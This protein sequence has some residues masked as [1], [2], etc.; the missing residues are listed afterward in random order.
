ME[1]ENNAKIGQHVLQDWTPY[2][3]YTKLQYNIMSSFIIYNV[4]EAGNN[5]KI[6]QPILQD[7]TPYNIYTKLQYNIMSSFIIAIFI[8][9]SRG[10]K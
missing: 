8:W 7:W 5:A 4:M 9:A 3:I 1:A 6:G 10:G 2:N